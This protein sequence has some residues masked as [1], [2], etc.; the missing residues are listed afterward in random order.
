MAL[1]G[2]LRKLGEPNCLPAFTGASNA[3]VGGA[4]YKGHFKNH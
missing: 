1:M 2:V 3:N 4:L